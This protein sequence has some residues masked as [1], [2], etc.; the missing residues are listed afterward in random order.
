M[1]S[2]L[3]SEYEVEYVLLSVKPASS[4]SDASFLNSLPPP[5]GGSGLICI[6]R[7]MPSSDFAGHLGEEEKVSIYKKCREIKILT[8]GT[9][10]GRSATE[11]P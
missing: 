9:C 5:L 3:L 6:A 11:L 2:F 7:F 1:A 4:S 8:L 10:L